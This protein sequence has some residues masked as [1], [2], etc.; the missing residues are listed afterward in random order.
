MNLLNVMKEE[1]FLV[2][3]WF[4]KIVTDKRKNDRRSVSSFGRYFFVHIYAFEDIEDR[5]VFFQ[6]S[7]LEDLED[8]RIFLQV[9]LFFV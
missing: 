5:S 3:D 9:H 2:L 1:K 8:G 7:I 4:P 6:H